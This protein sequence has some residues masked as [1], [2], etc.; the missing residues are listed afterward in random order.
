[1]NTEFDCEYTSQVVCPW[2]GHK[3]KDSWEFFAS[4]RNEGIDA[5]CESCDKPM[6]IN[7]HVTIQYTTKK[8]KK[9]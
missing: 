8:G 4:T 5:E 3:H 9:S 6:R 2:C 7:E 1:M